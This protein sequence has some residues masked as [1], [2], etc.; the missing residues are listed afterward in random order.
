MNVCRVIRVE[1]RGQVVGIRSRGG[2][3]ALGPDDRH[4]EQSC[5]PLWLVLISSL[6]WGVVGMHSSGFG[7]SFV[8]AAWRKGRGTIS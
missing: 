6:R 4:I 3:Q 1:V 5:R 2:I 8:R 7:F